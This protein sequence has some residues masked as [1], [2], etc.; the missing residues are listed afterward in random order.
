VKLYG[1]V[2]YP[3]SHS[4]SAKYFTAKFEK[5]QLTCCRYELFPLPNLSGFPNLIS[6]HPDLAGLNVTIP[7]KMTV[8]P[9]LDELDPAARETGSV[10]TIRVLR[11]PGRIILHGFNTDADGFDHAISGL[12]LPG[13][14]R[15]LILGTGGG[16]QAAAWVLRKKGL[17]CSFVSRN[18]QGKGCLT[19]GQVTEKILRECRVI[20]NA[21][22]AG[23]F[24]QTMTFP[25]LPYEH[26][27]G[28]H[29]LFDMVYNP[30]ETIFLKKGREKG[31]RVI[32][33]MKMLVVQAERS[34]QIWSGD[35]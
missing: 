3:L 27:S 16:A 14:D 1:L 20:V 22:P 29:L 24:P 33:G 9:Y 10:N 17:S 26:V 23:M 13:D 31:A 6:S 15:A 12:L 30:E 32:N 34:W 8:L 18:K 25:P 21:T 28:D 5:Q 7:H 2:G 35:Q 4:F 11:S 19:Y